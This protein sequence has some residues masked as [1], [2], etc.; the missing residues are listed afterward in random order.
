MDQMDTKIF[1]KF[2]IIVFSVILVVFF[3]VYYHHHYHWNH[4]CHLPSYTLTYI[5]YT[6]KW[7]KKFNPLPNISLFFGPNCF[8]FDF[9]IFN[10]TFFLFFLIKADLKTSQKYYRKRCYRNII[11]E[12]KIFYHFWN[13][14]VFVW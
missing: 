12:M 7:E 2:I 4:S 3:V 6:S 8:I 5:H 10:H 14:N 11:S 13:G 1:G 9:L